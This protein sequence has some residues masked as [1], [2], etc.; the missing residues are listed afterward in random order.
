MS[1]TNAPKTAPKTKSNKSECCTDR[2][3]ESGHRNRYFLGKQLSPYSFQMEQR[4]TLERRRLLNRA[5]HGWGVVYGFELSVTPSGSLL[6]KPG[7]ALDKSGRELLHVEDLTRTVGDL[8]VLDKDGNPS[9]LDKLSH[10]RKG[11]P[12]ECLLLSA[13]Y[14]EQYTDAVKVSDACQCEHMEWNYT[15]ETIRFSLQSIDCAECCNAYKCELDCQCASEGWCDK[16]DNAGQ[17]GGRGCLCAYV[18]ELPPGAECDKLC[19]IDE[20]CG[21]VRVDLK[22]GVRLAC[23]KLVGDN[24]DEWVFDKVEACGPRR[25]VKRNDLLFDLI[26]GCDLTRIKAIG[27]KDWHRGEISFDKFADA[28]GYYGDHQNQYV[29][30]AFWVEFSRPVRQDTLRPD[31]FAMTIMALE[32]EGGWWQTFRVPIVGVDT[33]LVPPQPNDPKDHVRSARIIVDG[34]WVEDG[35]RGRRTLFQ[36]SDTRIEIEVRGDFIIDCNGQAVDANAVGLSPFPTGNATPGGTFLST[37]H[38]AQMT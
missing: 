9:D 35:V 26:Q 6:I 10:S 31:C 11:A 18:T 12:P 30:D 7:L 15:C 36:D 38:V 27:W 28:L 23:V 21:S 1:T 34:A 4:Y 14:A 22:N 32:R 29:T 5:I 24:C 37:F 8:I 16:P 13:H 17:R 3:C 2:N 19:E 33:T 25:L 20:P